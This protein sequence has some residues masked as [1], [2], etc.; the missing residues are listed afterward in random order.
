MYNILVCDDERDIV[1]ALK[2]YLSA[3]GYNPVAAGNGREALRILENTEIHLILMDIMMPELDGIAATARLRESSNIPVILL[4]AKSEDT[5]KV[6]GLNIGADDYITKPFNPVELLARVKAQLR[7]YTHLGGMVKSEDVLCVGGIRLNDREKLVTLD[8]EPVTLTP[9]EYEILKFLM[10]TPGQ[11]F[12]SAQIYQ[13]VWND[14]AYK[15]EGAVAVHIRHLREKLEINPAEPRYLKV[16]W[17]Q[18]YKLER[19]PK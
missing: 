5:D 12:S 6:L 8:D 4:T 2:I 14:S 10:G 16:V 17:G 7:R 11:V 1:S 19:N 3:E 15:A 13:R 9:T 18:G